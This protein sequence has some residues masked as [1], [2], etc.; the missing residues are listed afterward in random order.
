MKQFISIVLC[1]V[2][3]V[4]TL[5]GCGSS[6]QTP[7]GG[8]AA[9]PEEEYR[10]L[11]ASE[12]TTLNY[13][14]TSTTYEMR[15]GVNMVDSLTEHDIYGVIQPS[16]A[17]SW[18]ANA[19][20]TVWT[21]KIR[22]GVK[23]VDVNGA[24]VA[25]V[26]AQDWVD[27]ARYVN[28]AG[29]ASSLQYMYEGIVK[30][31]SEY[32]SQTAD[33]QDAEKAVEDGSAAT[34]EEYYEASGIDPS[35]FITFDDV[36]VKALDDYTLE[37]T[38]EAPCPFFLS[39]LSYC[40]YMPAYGPFLEEMGGNFGLDNES[41]LYNGAY[42]LTE[43]SPNERHVFAANPTYWDKDKVYIKRVVST[44]N[45]DT[46]T[47]APTML[48]KGEI[49]EATIGADILDNWMNNPDTSS[50]VRPSM[51]VI[52]Y[53]YFYAFNFEPRFDA[54][55]EPDNW[56]K[57]VNNENFR[58]ALLHGLDRLKALAVQDPYNPE[59][60][61]NN[62]VT[63]K[64]FAVGA[65][66]D[67][68][69]YGPISAI[70][71]GNSF[72]EAKAKEYRD[73]AKTELAAAGATFPVKALMPYNPVVTNW[74]NECQV[75]EQQLEALLGADFIDIIVETG[76]ET[77]FLGEV[78]RS[79]KYAFMKCNWGADYADPQTWTDPFA[80]GN[81]YNF[82]YTDAEK[83][84]SDIPATNKTEST[85]SLVSEYYALVAAAKSQTRDIAARYG[86]F[87][88]AEAFLI[89]HAVIIPFSIDTDGYVATRVDPFSSMFAPYG[90]SMFK[91]KLVK[92]L[93]RPMDAE[94]FNAAYE[95]WLGEWAAAQEKADR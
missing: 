79:G 47:L 70:S 35:A 21:F 49:D 60:L 33:E 87:A 48:Q 91:Y 76:P 92:L 61:L 12:Y 67:F 86:A 74:A 58:K 77:G 57:A 45:A 17:E 4:V 64:T 39:V 44:Y 30:N 80:A 37:Y 43:Y 7:A 25:E 84:L 71:S 68:T 88:S 9:A 40:S 95:K 52:S 53:S 19:D 50:L 2:L 26:T 55:Y 34:A 65:G 27:A 20:N 32:Y 93:D 28:D 16:L 56:I 5:A 6:G 46:T 38:M 90:M 85:Q 82:M 63:P 62:T 13:L 75:V 42:I 14:I 11:Y 29:N 8:Q 78:R 54:Q 15:A 89:D 69:A 72:D 41:L 83:V 3:A 23:W 73:L 81:S 24:E 51:P 1:A 10:T 66:K 94:S 22:Q 18:T 36:G 31:A 59:S